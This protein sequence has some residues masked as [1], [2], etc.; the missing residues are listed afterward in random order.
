MAGVIVGG[1]VV[2]IAE[3]LH[4]A[5]AGG[6]DPAALQ[7]ALQ[8]GF[9]GSTTLREHGLRMVQRDSKPAGPAT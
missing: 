5:E 2:A 7:Q 4:F 1:T 6:T 9:A 3:A 8:G